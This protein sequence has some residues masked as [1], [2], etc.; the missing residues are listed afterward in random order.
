M[1]LPSGSGLW[2]TLYTA[3]GSPALKVA[4][5]PKVV[6]AMVNEETVFR[7]KLKKSVP[8]GAKA[9]EGILKFAANFNPPQNVGNTLD[10]GTLAPAKDRTEA[11]YTLVPSLFTFSMQIGLVTRE[12]ANSSKSAWNGGEL[13]R[14]T[15]EVMVDAAKYIESSYTGTH[16]TGRR[17]RVESDG[18]N[19]FVAALPEGTRLLREN[20]YIS[21]RTTDGGAT[22]GV[23]FRKIT[24][25]DH[26]TRTV[27]YDGADGALV[28][29]QHI[30]VVVEASQDITTSNPYPNGLR[31]L[32]DDTTFTSTHHGLSKSTY[33][34]LK[35][36]VFSNGGTLRNLTEQLLVRACHEIRARSG[37]RITDIWTSEGQMEKYLEF[38][39]PDRRLIRNSPGDT[40]NMATGY[41][42]TEM[43]HYG[44]GIE[45]K[46]NYSYDIV[47][48]ELYLLNWDTFFHYQAKELGWI[49]GIDQLLPTPGS[50]AYKG[51]LLGYP[52]ALENIGCDMPLANGV[53]RD[54]K[55]PAIGDV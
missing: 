17:A 12:I 51:S 32:V 19:N 13:R 39:A 38:V 18:S 29:G 24:A 4:Y 54:L 21:E 46:L 49:D 30:H 44:P 42:G 23:D 25:I 7:P 45:V 10:G 31:G 36:N 20:F 8:A 11:Q 37:K 33:P 34:K 40:G 1:A 43:V 27:T 55:D 5:A 2:D 41:K 9:S 47:P 22:T 52:I 26:S 14:R 15:D 3:T 6:E 16:G 53:I 50:S 48:R 35:A 28:A